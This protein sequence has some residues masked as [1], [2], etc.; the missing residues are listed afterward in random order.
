MD[1]K[2]VRGG[3][4]MWST[5]EEEPRAELPDHSDLLKL[6]PRI[7]D[8]KD[9][10][11]AADKE[12]KALVSQAK[13]ILAEFREMHGDRY[14][15]LGLDVT[16]YESGGTPRVDM[17]V[18]REKLMSNGVSPDL[19]KQ[20]EEAASTPTKKSLSLRVTRVRGDSPEPE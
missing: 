19:Y 15:G 6:L 1:T 3:I 4:P 14:H 10:K 12:E 8:V 2:K 7:R 16:I 5:N 20:C 13:D 11:E 9:T 18:L 17:K